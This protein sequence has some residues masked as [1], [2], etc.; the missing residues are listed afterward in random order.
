MR[1]PNDLCSRALDGSLAGAS[2]RE[3]AEALIGQRLVHSDWNDPRDHL[4]DRMRR[5]VSRGRAL[6]NGGYLDFLV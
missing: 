3:I 2:H 5:A 1:R 4:H 6:M